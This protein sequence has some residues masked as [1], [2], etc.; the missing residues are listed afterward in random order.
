[1]WERLHRNDWRA[2]VTDTAEKRFTAAALDPGAL[3]AWT[4]GDIET[5]EAAK[6]VADSRVPEHDCDCPDWQLRFS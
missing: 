1:M 2:R 5:F 6:E 3:S 4:T